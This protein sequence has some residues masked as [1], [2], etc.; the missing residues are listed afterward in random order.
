MKIKLK[1]KE[2]VDNLYPEEELSDL[3]IMESFYHIRK[4]KALSESLENGFIHIDEINDNKQ[5]YSVKYEIWFNYNE[6]EII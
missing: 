6:Y 5:C 3:S 2:L 4:L 1:R